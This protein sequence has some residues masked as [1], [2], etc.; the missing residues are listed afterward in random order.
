ML[1]RVDHWSPRGTLLPQ[2]GDVCLVAPDDEGHMWLA[3]WEPQATSQLVAAYEI[4]D[5]KFSALAPQGGLWLPCDGRPITIADD[6][7]ALRAGLL[8]IS[9][10]YGTDGTGNPRIPDLRDRVIVGTG[11]RHPPGDSFG[12]ASVTLTAEQIAPHTHPVVPGALY[13]EIGAGGGRDVPTS[14]SGRSSYA[15][16]TATANT[17]GQPHP[18]EQPSLA[19]PAYILAAL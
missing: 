5:V 18:N 11:S 4:G 10:P 19:I 16:A 17:G 15:N 3:E 13:F 14:A 1:T 12:S 8:S 2:P 9:S 6:L 7:P